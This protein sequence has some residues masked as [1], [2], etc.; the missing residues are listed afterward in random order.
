MSKISLVPIGLKSTENS[1]AT[2]FNKP[3]VESVEILPKHCA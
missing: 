3:I 2:P 1:F